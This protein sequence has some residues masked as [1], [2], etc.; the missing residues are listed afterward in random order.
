MNKRT[1]FPKG[2]F[3]QGQ[4][5]VEEIEVLINILRAQ[6]EV[7]VKS[8]FLNLFS[9]D[10]CVIGPY[11]FP[12]ERGRLDNQLIRFTMWSDEEFDVTTGATL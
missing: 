1:F 2:D 6:I 5:P 7:D 8:A 9:I 10:R 11:E 12:Q 3:V 4:R